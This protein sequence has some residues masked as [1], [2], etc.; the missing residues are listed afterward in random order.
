MTKEKFSKHFINDRMER[1]VFIA[2][3]VGIGDVV[4]TTQQIDKQNRNAIYELT[5]KGVLIIRDVTD[6]TI[7]TMYCPTLCQVKGIFKQ[8]VSVTMRN[9]I[10]GNEKKGFCNI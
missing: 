1:Y 10:R 5:K 4:Y 6:R 2:T 9:V 8:D 7:I 3:K